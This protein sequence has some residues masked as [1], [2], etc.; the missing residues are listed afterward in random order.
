[1]TENTMAPVS[2]R[3]EDLTPEKMADWSGRLVHIQSDNGIWCPE[4]RGYTNNLVDAWKVDFETAY[5]S[6][7]HC[8][9]EKRVRYLKAALSAEDQ[10]KHLSGLLH[11]AECEVQ[12]LQCRVAELETPEAYYPDPAWHGYDSLKD[13]FA[14]DDAGLEENR[15]HEIARSA[16]LPSIWAVKIGDDIREF[17]DEQDA[18]NFL[19]NVEVSDD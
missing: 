8:G 3:L 9:P 11:E 17:E 5:R 12:R 4:G 16:H 19:L 6:T 15:A 2:I 10:I 1:M 13:A 7:R 18:R 14:D